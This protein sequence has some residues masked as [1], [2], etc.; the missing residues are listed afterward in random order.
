MGLAHLDWGPIHV[1]H[2]PLHVR[3]K[4]SRQAMAMAI[5]HVQIPPELFCEAAPS[6][7]PEELETLETRDNDAEHPG[8]GITSA[9]PNVLSTPAVGLARA[10]SSGVL[11]TN[12]SIEDR[13]NGIVPAG[14][15]AHAAAVLNA[16]RRV[17]LQTVAI[18]QA[19]WRDT[20]A[21]AFRMTVA[22]GGKEGVR[23]AT[24]GAHT[25]A[26]STPPRESSRRRSQHQPPTHNRA[27]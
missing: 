11:L 25:G 20:Y 23:K 27:R 9:P 19:L 3:P 17:Y 8:S 18:L 10:C 15:N 13:S 2:W 16:N 22:S 1:T 6:T 26:V 12:K 24:L 7:L 14:E 5:I 21:E 4:R